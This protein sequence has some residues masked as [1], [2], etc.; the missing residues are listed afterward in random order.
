MIWI[1]DVGLVL[2]FAV[3]ATALFRFTA[4]PAY[5]ELVRVGELAGLLRVL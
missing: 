1:L 5:A 3:L 4:K 2:A